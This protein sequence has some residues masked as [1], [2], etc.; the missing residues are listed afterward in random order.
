M[1]S[2]TLESAILEVVDDVVIERVMY[3]ESDPALDL[4]NAGE[5]K[6]REGIT[7]EYYSVTLFADDVAIGELVIA[8]MVEVG[9]GYISDLEITPAY[10]NRGFG[11]QIISSLLEMFESDAEIE[12]VFVVPTT[13]PM[14]R[15]VVQQGFNEVNWDLENWYVKIV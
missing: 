11:S 9:V 14:E 1:D 2:S 4:F 7:T 8:E 15:I 12:R 6:R 5:I 13:E 3:E 10:R